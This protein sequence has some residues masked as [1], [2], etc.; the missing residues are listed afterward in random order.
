MP[1]FIEQRKLVEELA[2]Y[3]SKMKRKDYDEFEMMRKRIRDDEELDQLTLR[4]LEELRELYIP[5][6]KRW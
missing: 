1:S 5:A 3:H 6:D 4:R 2:Q